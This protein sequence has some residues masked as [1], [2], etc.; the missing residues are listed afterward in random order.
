MASLTDTSFGVFDGQE[1]EKL[2]PLPDLV[3]QL[4]TELAEAKKQLNEWRSSPSNTDV[5]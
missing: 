4:Q 3:K 5:K 2:R 1:L